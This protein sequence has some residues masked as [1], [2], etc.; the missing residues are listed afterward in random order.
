MAARVAVVGGGTSAGQAAVW[1]ARAG[2]VVTLLHRRSDLRETMSEYLIAELGRSGVALRGNSEIAGPHGSGGAL[3]AV[4]LTDG[5]RAR[6]SFVV[7]FRDAAPHTDWLDGA[8]A[9]DAHGFVLT[10]GCRVGHRR[11]KRASPESSPQETCAGSVKRAATAVAEGAVVVQSVHERFSREGA[12]E[13][14]ER[15]PPRTRPLATSSRPPS[16]PP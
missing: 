1:L 4:T 14:R 10:A 13:T 15:Q 11:W 3:D 12:R 8:V 6:Y 16:T 9:S 2:A 7:L 5:S